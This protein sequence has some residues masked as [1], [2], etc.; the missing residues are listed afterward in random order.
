MKKSFFFTLVFIICGFTNAV[1]QKTG[2]RR[3]TVEAGRYQRINTPVSSDI[4]DILISDN[5]SYQLFEIVRGKEVE[6]PCQ[7]ETGYEA[8]IWAD[9]AYPPVGKVTK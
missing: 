2:L 9:I 6:T 8:R 7:A 1:A 3:F 4:S 5:L